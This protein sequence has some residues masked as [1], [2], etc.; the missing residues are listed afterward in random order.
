MD[1][2]QPDMVELVEQEM[3]I[4]WADSVSIPKM[5]KEDSEFVHLIID[6][7]WLERSFSKRQMVIGEA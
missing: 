6:G 5:L 7:I 3:K 4:L 1:I 2:E